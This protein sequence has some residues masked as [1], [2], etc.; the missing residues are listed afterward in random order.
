MSPAFVIHILPIPVVELPHVGGVASTGFDPCDIF[1]VTAY[2]SAVT[3]DD[4]T[5]TLAATAQRP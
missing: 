1:A 5:F 4:E 3:V 2:S